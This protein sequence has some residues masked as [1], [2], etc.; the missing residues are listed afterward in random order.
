MQTLTNII[1]QLYDIWLE[2]PWQEKVSK[3]EIIHYFDNMLAS[4][5]IYVIEEDGELLGF[6]ERIFKDD[7]CFLKNVFAFRPGIFKKLYRHFF[8][9]MPYYIKKITG[10]KQKLQG[11]RVIETISNARR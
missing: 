1:E 7:T 9:T 8:D 5:G 2:T 10:D 6:Y 11:K 4:G 3:E